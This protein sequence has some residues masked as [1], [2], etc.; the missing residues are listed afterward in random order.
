M[1]GTENP[2]VETIGAGGG[3]RD[4]PLLPCHDCEAEERFMA[5]KRNEWELEYLDDG[6]GQWV[7]YCPECSDTEGAT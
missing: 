6:S 3:P 5:M 1:T 7:A 4:D 2:G